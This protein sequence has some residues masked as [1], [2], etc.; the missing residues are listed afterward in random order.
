MKALRYEDRNIFLS[1]LVE[2]WEVKTSEVF[3]GEDLETILIIKDWDYS[4]YHYSIKIG[5]WL[6]AAWDGWHVVDDNDIRDF[7]ETIKSCL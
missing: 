6:I 2:D 1:S 5:Q 4:K 7:Y 3:V